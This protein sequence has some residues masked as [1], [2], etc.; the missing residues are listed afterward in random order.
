MQYAEP[1]DRHGGGTLAVVPALAGHSAV[2]TGNAS[3]QCSPLADIILLV[4]STV[5]QLRFSIC[6]IIVKRNSY[7]NRI[8]AAET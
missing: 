6:I 4:C 2:A 3:W 1:S 7:S 8:F 5:V